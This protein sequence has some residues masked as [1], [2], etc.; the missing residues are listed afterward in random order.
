MVQNIVLVARYEGRFLLME[1]TLRSKVQDHLLKVRVY[2]L[3]I[4]A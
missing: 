2:L 3:C 4:A 1:M